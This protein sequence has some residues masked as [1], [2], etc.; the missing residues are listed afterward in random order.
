[1]AS[2]N[3]IMPAN[4]LISLRAEIVDE[5]QL[6]SENFPHLIAKMKDEM[7]LLPEFNFQFVLDGLKE[8]KYYSGP[9]QFLKSI[10]DAF[11][12]WPEVQNNEKQLKKVF[13]CYLQL[14]RAAIQALM[15]RSLAKCQQATALAETISN[16]TNMHEMMRLILLMKMTSCVALVSG[17][18]R[19]LNR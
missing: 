11:K 15:V 14:P 8:V 13:K 6:K 1:M 17:L 19:I 7:S 10:P 4:Q 9:S 3:F 16:Q 12:S 18:Y 5:N 2:S